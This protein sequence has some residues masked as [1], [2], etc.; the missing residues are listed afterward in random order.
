MRKHSPPF[1]TH[2]LLR[3]SF[4]SSLPRTYYFNPLISSR[5]YFVCTCLEMVGI[6]E[7]LVEPPMPFEKCT[8][9]AA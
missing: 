4:P 8:M 9:H 3:V 1:I 5:Y 7:A 6:Y 2:I